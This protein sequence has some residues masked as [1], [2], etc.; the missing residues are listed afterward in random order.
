MLINFYIFRIEYDAISASRVSD[1]LEQLLPYEVVGIDEG[2]FYDDVNL[3]L[4]IF[5]LKFKFLFFT[6]AYNNI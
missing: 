2:Q 3:N 1:V 4:N 6:F 5:I